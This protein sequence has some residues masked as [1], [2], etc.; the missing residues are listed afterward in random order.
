MLKQAEE[1][2]KEID[3]DIFPIPG[4]FY[5]ELLQRTNIL[6]NPGKLAIIE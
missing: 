6:G 2:E 5:V 3:F 4:Y 1:E